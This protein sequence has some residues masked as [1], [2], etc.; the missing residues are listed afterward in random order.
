MPH[1]Q[2]A[3][4]RKAFVENWHVGCEDKTFCIKTRAGLVGGDPTPKPA[5]KADQRVFLL[6][7]RS[8]RTALGRL[9][10]P[11][12]W[13]YVA[14]TS[15]STGRTYWSPFKSLLARIP[16]NSDPR[17]AQNSLTWQKVSYCSK[18]Y[19]K[20]F[21]RAICRFRGDYFLTARRPESVSLAKH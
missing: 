1:V 6:Y 13:I 8:L 11:A 17:F 7:P 20:V 2:A 10:V 15:M 19:S 12:F 21:F 14:H 18:P 3:S 9:C 5:P 16:F 4:V